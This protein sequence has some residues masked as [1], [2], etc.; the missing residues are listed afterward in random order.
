[1]NKA[2][3][4]RIAIKILG[5]AVTA[6]IL[7][8][9][10]PAAALPGMGS[11]A[12]AR[13]APRQPL[14]PF[15]P[16]VMVHQDELR[17]FETLTDHQFSSSELSQVQKAM[18]QANELNQNLNGSE[19]VQNVRWD[20][21]NTGYEWTILLCGSFKLQADAIIP[22]RAKDM[23]GKLGPA[24]KDKVTG[25]INKGNAELVPCFDPHTGKSYVMAGG[26]S[27]FGAPSLLTAGFTIGF[28]FNSKLEK[29]IVGSYIFGRATWNIAVFGRWDITGGGDLRCLDSAISIA[30][31][32][33]VDFSKCSRFFVSTGLGF[34]LGGGLMSKLKK[35]RGVASVPDAAAPGGKTLDL[36]AWSFSYG[37]IVKVNEFPWYQRMR[38]GLGLR[39]TFK[40]LDTYVAANQ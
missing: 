21:G 36:G 17:E 5:S 35:L 8:A 10:I 19:G 2:K 13:P 26:G 23:L 34:D 29:A 22:Q 40:D 38:Q 4:Q 32:F 14:G 9:A 33:K 20:L 18:D 12:I 37:V 7:L 6:A 25:I 24:L 16:A 1:M 11:A 28:Y 39:E 15:Q 3:V 31:E 30:T 27:T